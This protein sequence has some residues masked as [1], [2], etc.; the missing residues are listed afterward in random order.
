MTRTIKLV[1]LTN[2]ACKIDS[3]FSGMISKE[4]SKK[5]FQIQKKSEFLQL[6]D[7]KR[8]ICY[9]FSWLKGHT[10]NISYWQLCYN[11]NILPAGKMPLMS[12][13]TYAWQ[14]ITD[15]PLIS[16]FSRKSDG[17]IYTIYSFYIDYPVTVIGN[18]IYISLF[19]SIY[20]SIWERPRGLVATEQ[21]YYIVVSEF[22]HLLRKCVHFRTNT[23]GEGMNNLIPPT[24]CL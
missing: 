11:I 3:P 10:R 5:F 2:V 22:E 21:D 12:P 17:Y 15:W 1:T 8:P 7:Y 6:C 20:L 9:H 4:T 19:I 24:I 16:Q 18:E 14:F 13:F 23:H